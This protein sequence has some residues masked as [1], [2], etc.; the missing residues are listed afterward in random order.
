MAT[1]K[2]STPRG[3]ETHWKQLLNGWSGGRLTSAFSAAYADQ[4]PTNTH[5]PA[6]SPSSTPP[7]PPSAGRASLFHTERLVPDDAPQP[8]TAVSRRPVIQVHRAVAVSRKLAGE[9]H[10]QRHKKPAHEVLPC[11]LS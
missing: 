8:R 9:H 3:Y 10:R 2:P 11:S 5:H 6:P 4:S 7:S 1:S